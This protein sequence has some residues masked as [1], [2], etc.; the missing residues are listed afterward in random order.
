MTAKI[1]W[2]RRPAPKPREA[3]LPPS[4]RGIHP[5][6]ASTFKAAAGTELGRFGLRR[7]K[8]YYA[9]RSSCRGGLVASFSSYPSSSAVLLTRP[10]WGGLDW[11]ATDFPIRGA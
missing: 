4:K 8:A 11:L 9:D 10:P 1:P 5:V 7:P 6:G 3:T 2:F